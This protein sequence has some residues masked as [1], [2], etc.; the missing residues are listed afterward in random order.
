MRSAGVSDF[1]TK[2]FSV[3]ELR[4]RVKAAMKHGSQG[5]REAFASSHF[6]K[7]STPAI[8]R[9]MIFECWRT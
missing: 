9:G 1:M 8:P 7:F 2:P 4:D 6:E 5:L 3:R